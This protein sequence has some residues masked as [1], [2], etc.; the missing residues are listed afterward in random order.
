MRLGPGCDSRAGVL[1]RGPIA[2]ATAEQGQRVLGAASPHRGGAGPERAG[3]RPAG[4]GWGAEDGISGGSCP[5]LVAAGLLR[6]PRGQ[7]RHVG[8]THITEQPD[9]PGLCLRL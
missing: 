4:R 9:E 5:A 1:P 6:S 7:N 3:C 2:F 8:E